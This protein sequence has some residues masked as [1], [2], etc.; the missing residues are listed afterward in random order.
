MIVDAHI[1]IWEKIDGRIA[2]DVHVCGLSGGMIRIGHRELLG[3]PAYLLDCAAKAEYVIAEFDAAGVDLGIVVQEYMDGIQ[4]DY[5]RNA[6]NKFSGRLLAFALPN[7]W[8]IDNVAAEAKHLLSS[9]YCGL[10]LPAEHLLGKIR[11]DDARLMP[12]WRYLEE[13]Q[14]VLAVDLADGESQ[15]EEMESILFCFPKLCV[16]IGH[17]G[18][19]NCKG[20]SSQLRLARHQNVYLEMGGIIWLFRSEGYPFPGAINAIC[21]AKREVGIEKLM[22]GSDWPRTMIDFTYR[23]SLDFIRISAVFTEAEKALL[24]G[25]NARKLYRLPKPLVSRKAVALITED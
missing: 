19:V 13:S 25:E 18:M 15:A 24:L 14:Q 2:N 10:K 11:L 17:F 21:Q 22:W 8:A 20:W 5:T 7:Y 23:Q 9:N 16:A 4:N 12:I 6:V 1:H 3:M